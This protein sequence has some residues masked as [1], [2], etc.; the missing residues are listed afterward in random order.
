MIVTLTFIQPCFNDSDLDAH[1][2]MFQDNDSDR[3][4]HV[5]MF[6][7]NDSDLDALVTMF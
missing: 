7:D 1:V 3:D 2:T 4:A 5:P 6:Q